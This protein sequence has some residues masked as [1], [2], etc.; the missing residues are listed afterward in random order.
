KPLRRSL[1][2]ERSAYHRKLLHMLEGLKRSGF[3]R[4]YER[5]M[6][7]LE[8]MN[9]DE[10]TVVG[11]FAVEA[12]GDRLQDVMDNLHAVTGRYRSSLFH[13][14][15][16]RVKKLKYA[17]EPF[18]PILPA[19]AEEL[20]GM[21]SDLQE[22]MGLV[23]DLDVQREVVADWVATHGL[24]DGLRLALQQIA[25]RRRDLLAQT[26]GHVKTMAEQECEAR[27]Q[28][29]LQALADQTVARQAAG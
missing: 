26:R 14:Q 7:E 16:I 2:K 20:Y 15:R 5:L 11:Q 13:R 22:L 4:K 9:G 8:A 17:L 29:V 3:G 18:L 6:A 1:A 12:I 28:Q 10:P 25:R 24:S 19:E 27:L 21:V 23:H